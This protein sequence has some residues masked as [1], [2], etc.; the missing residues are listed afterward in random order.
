LPAAQHPESQHDY[1]STL[2]GEE[3]AAPPAPAGLLV[4]AAM[5][6]FLST[7]S[8]LRAEEWSRA[9]PAA[10]AHQLI[11]GSAA[12][13]IRCAP[14]PHPD[15]AYRTDPIVGFLEFGADIS[16][17][18]MY[19]GARDRYWLVNLVEVSPGTYPDHLAHFAPAID[20]ATALAQYYQGEPS[21]IERLSWGD[22][23]STEAYAG[24]PAWLRRS[25]P[26][27]LAA[28]LLVAFIGVAIA[29]E[30][31]TY[32]AEAD[33]DADEFED[34]EYGDLLSF[35]PAAVMP[36]EA[37]VPPVFT[38]IVMPAL[39][40]AGPRFSEP[41]VS[42]QEEMDRLMAEEI[43]RLREELGAI[44]HAADMANF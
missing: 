44:T 27:G 29:T 19:D 26:G 39:P 6:V 5:L 9:V 38:P 2:A 13:A 28:L 33:D 36:V 40:P 24:L 43:R 1:S 8:P 35:P 32:E 25:L 37:V 3:E 4:L 42:P 30:Y 23:P 20:R 22:L 10:L 41:A 7:S 12:Q 11:S 15:P 14:C 17:L 34:E 21:R 31:A 18:Y 16:G